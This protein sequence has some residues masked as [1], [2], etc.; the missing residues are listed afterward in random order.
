LQGAEARR[1]SKAR[2]APSRRSSVRVS[3]F[4]I[5]VAARRR[6]RSDP[7]R[8]PRYAA[9][10]RSDRGT[11]GP[12][13]GQYQERPFRTLT[14][15]SKKQK[16]PTGS[17]YDHVD[18]SLGSQMSVEPPWFDFQSHSVRR[19]EG[20]KKGGHGWKFVDI[21]E[22]LEFGNKK[23]TL[24]IWALQ[25]LIKTMIQ[26]GESPPFVRIFNRA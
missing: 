18:R 13:G 10:Q 8:S 24:D 3:N 26:P 19:K 7:G 16:L 12:H 25:R 1:P 15:L 9:D 20:R 23:I 4:E 22:K 2:E 17:P 11:M 14:Q 5:G 6:H 21:P